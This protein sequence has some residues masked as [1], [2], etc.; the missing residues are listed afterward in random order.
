MGVKDNLDDFEIIN[1]EEIKQIKTQE[2]EN[3]AMDKVVKSDIEKPTSLL[4]NEKQVS[5]PVETQALENRQKTFDL[6]SEKKDS[7][8]YEEAPKTA[9]GKQKSS[10][11]SKSSDSSESSESSSSSD[12]SSSKKSNIKD[13]DTDKSKLLTKD[14]NDQLK[15]DCNDT[16]TKMDIGQETDIQMTDIKSVSITEISCK[17]SDAEETLE[18]ITEKAVGASLQKV[19]IES[20]EKDL[21]QATD[22]L[23]Q[24]EDYLKQEEENLKQ[25]KGDLKQE[26]ADHNEKK[27]DFQEE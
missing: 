11:S 25:E 15:T 19:S 4:Q 27:D 12:S 3:E 17:E 5:P 20:R 2:I 10:E 1:D 9:E 22:D 16:M 21:K 24:N 8:I 13:N 23:K 26:I 18:E 14:N 6:P 7:E